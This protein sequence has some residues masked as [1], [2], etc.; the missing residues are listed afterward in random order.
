[1][2]DKAVFLGG[3]KMF[4][5]IKVFFGPVNNSIKT[6][7]KTEEVKRSSILAVA[8]SIT[9]WTVISLLWEIFS[10]VISDPSFSTFIESLRTL[11]NDKN[12]IAVAIALGTFVLDVLRRKYM[13]GR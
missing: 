12:W 10:T 6:E 2:L 7:I 13:H 8:S 11:V 4:E 5:G 9:V 1:M 3:T